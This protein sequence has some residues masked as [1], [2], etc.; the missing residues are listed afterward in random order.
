[1]FS[2][3]VVEQA[4]AQL[5]AA[6]DEQQY[7]ALLNA[8]NEY[9]DD[10]D[11]PEGTIWRFTKRYASTA[12]G[13]PGRYT[14]VA[15]KAPKQWYITG[16]RGGMDWDDFVFWLLTHGEPVYRSEIS[17]VTPTAEF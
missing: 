13:I 9:C 10:V 8:L 16:I 1:M 6:S 12:A 5:K 7:L 14:Y 4:K 15:F 17:E 11:T 3:E 2:P